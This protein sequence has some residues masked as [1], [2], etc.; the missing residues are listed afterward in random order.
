MVFYGSGTSKTGKGVL[1]ALHAVPLQS[2]PTACSVLKF[3]PLFPQP[4]GKFA[5]RV[6]LRP[7]LK[8]DMLP[9]SL[10][11][12]MENTAFFPIE[13]LNTKLLSNLNPILFLNIFIYLFIFLTLPTTFL[14][15]AINYL[16]VSYLHLSSYVVFQPLYF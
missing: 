3:P 10:E 8:L 7:T 14:L 9:F 12:G 13:S 5:V 4:S 2:Q 1:Q 11:K 6:S 16:E 15:V